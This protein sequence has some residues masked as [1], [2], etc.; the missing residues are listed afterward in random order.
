[1]ALRLFARLAE[2]EADAVVALLLLASVAEVG[3]DAVEALLLLARLA[4]AVADAAAVDAVVALV[5]LARLAGKNAPV[6]IGHRFGEVEIPGARPVLALPHKAWAHGLA[7]GHT[8]CGTAS[9]HSVPAVR[10][11]AQ[12]STSAGLFAVAAKIQERQDLDSKDLDREV[13]GQGG[14]SREG[15]G[16]KQR[17]VDQGLRFAAKGGCS[18][19]QPIR[20]HRLVW[21]ALECGLGG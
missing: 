11:I 6:A 16:A 2:V 10:N 17:V 7:A 12:I 15:I 19:V 9:A 5:L 8:E 4:E 3:V 14:G 13:A 18:I 21:V 1:V 20:R